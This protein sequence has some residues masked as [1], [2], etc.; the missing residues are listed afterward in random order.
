MRWICQQ[1]HFEAL[2]EVGPL[3]PG[4]GDSG[5]FLEIFYGLGI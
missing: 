4:F 3:T 1:S 5:N 2:K